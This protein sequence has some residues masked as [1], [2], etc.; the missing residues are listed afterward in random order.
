MIINLAV[1]ISPWISKEF[2]RASSEIKP[3]LAADQSIEQRWYVEPLKY[4]L[5]TFK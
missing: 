5:L 1:H 2:L 3:D 4:I